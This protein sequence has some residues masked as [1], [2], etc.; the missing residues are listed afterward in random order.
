MRRPVI[1]GNWKMNPGT[2][3]DALS[4][5]AKVDRAAAEAPDVTTVVCPPAIWL[6]EVAR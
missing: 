3:D 5:A 4:L 1:A 6:A 2:L